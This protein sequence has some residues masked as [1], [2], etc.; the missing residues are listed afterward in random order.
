MWKTIMMFDYDQ[1]SSGSLEFNG[2]LVVS[3]E[4][5]LFLKALGISDEKYL[6]DLRLIVKKIIKLQYE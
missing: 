5:L 1:L 2:L 3:L 4:K 6:E